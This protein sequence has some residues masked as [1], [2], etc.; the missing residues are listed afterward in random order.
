MG[1]CWPLSLVDRG[2]QGVLEEGDRVKI[3]NVERNKK[4]EEKCVATLKSPRDYFSAAKGEGA[5]LDRL[6]ELVNAEPQI[7]T[8][9][10]NLLQFIFDEQREWMRQNTGH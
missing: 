7:R 1:D 10:S 9:S 2:K 8:V 5:P 4:N 6:K 3:S